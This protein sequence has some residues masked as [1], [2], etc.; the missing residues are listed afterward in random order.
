MFN[1][2]GGEVILILLV[3]LVVLG[4]EKLPDAMRRAGHLYG[5]LRRMSQGFQSELRSALDEP[6]RELRNTADLARSVVEEP[7]KQVSSLAD[8]VKATVRGEAAVAAVTEATSATPAT[9]SDDPLDPDALDPDDLD[10][11]L[12]ELLADDG[13]DEP[14]MGEPGDEVAEPGE[15]GADAARPVEAEPVG[16]DVSEPG[17]PSL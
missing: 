17:L 7:A 16:D 6:M 10:D 5:E 4:P 11:E 14:P 3:A 9:L 12:P 13:P 1:I 15:P 2:T 8:D